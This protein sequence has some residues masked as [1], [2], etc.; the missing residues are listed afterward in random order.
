MKKKLAALTLSALLV[1]ALPIAVSAHGHRA[2]Q[3]S[4]ILNHA[5]CV[6]VSGISGSEKSGDSQVCPGAGCAEN[7]NHCH[8][9]TAG[10]Q[11]FAGDGEEPRQNCTVQGCQETGGHVHSQTHCR[12]KDQ[13]AGHG[14][15]GGRH[16]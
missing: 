13:A 5:A 8:T 12:R 1:A 11:S 7:E 6:S 16:H 4:Q 9:I 3:S 2:G 14:C 10:V 15:H